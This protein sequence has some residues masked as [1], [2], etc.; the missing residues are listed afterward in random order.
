MQL[1]TTLD[2]P[3]QDLPS[4]PDPIRQ[5]AAKSHTPSPSH[6]PRFDLNLARISLVLDIIAF[7]I[8]LLSSKGLLFV[9]GSFIQSLGSGYSP[10]LQAF[11]LEV[12]SRRGGKGEAGRLFGAFSVLSSVG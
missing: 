11:A 6:T 4:H 7:S 3:L 8:M 5:S 2:E 9:C 12:Y 1:P 10:A